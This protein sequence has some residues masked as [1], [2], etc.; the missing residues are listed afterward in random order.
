LVFA[1]SLTA[2]FLDFDDL[3]FLA[4]NPHLRD[5]S[6]ADLRWMFGANWVIWYPVTWLT[7]VSDRLLWG[8]GA[9]GYH[10]TNV[11]LH[12]LNAALAFR[13]FDRM[14]EAGGSNEP[15]TR[16]AAAAFAALLFA[17]HPLRVESVTWASERSDVLCAAF[18]LGTV[19]AW[20]DGRPA[21]A[22]VLHALGLASKGSNVALPLALAA[23]DALAVTGPARPRGRR[24]AAWL[25]A[26]LALSAADGL[27]NVSLQRGVGAAWEPS[28]FGI[29]DRLAI[30]G[31]SYAHGAAKTLWPTGLE[32]LYPM[33]RPFDPAAPGFLLAALAVA[34]L[35]AAAWRIRRRAPGAAGAWG[36]YLLLAAPTAGFFKIGAHLFAD[37]YTYLPALGFAGLAGE[38]LRRV[39]PRARRGAAAGALAA[40]T[41]LAALT[42]RR[43]G[44]WLD[45]D[46][47]WSAMVETDPRN[48]LAR[49]YLGLRR[50]REGRG[51]DAERLLREAIAVD[52]GLGNAHNDLGNILANTGR[53]EEAIVHFRA[54]LAASPEHPVTR[55]NLALALIRTGRGDEAASALR[56]ELTLIRARPKDALRDSFE[57]PPDEERTRRLLSALEAR[58]FVR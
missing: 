30:A 24:A 15:R 41:V 42:W 58:G 44:D 29:A 48:G 50:L 52:P 45:A 7:W 55:Y 13:L 28:A 9:F 4:H 26:M 5:P 37:R 56:D 54:A 36:A 3:R 10:L 16:R 21:R 33:P 11:L 57:P 8:G 27:L 40:L 18:A 34:A 19:L 39:P 38:G 51:A 14:M 17:L 31:A 1:R 35:T 47:F 2:G 43:Q 46:R 25:S 49:T 12:A 23:L 6:W 20:I 53:P 22:L 32:G